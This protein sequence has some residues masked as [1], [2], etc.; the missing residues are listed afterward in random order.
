MASDTSNFLIAE[1]QLILDEARRQKSERIK[2]LGSPIQLS[3]KAL[4]IQVR[5]N[6]AWVA[7]NTAVARKL[8]LESGKTVQLYKGHTGPVTTL[9]FC[10]KVF[11]SGDEKILITGAWDQTIKLWDAD[12]K[13]LLSSTSEAHGDFVKSLFVLPSLNLLV[14]SGS[15]KIVRFWDLSTPQQKESLRSMGS[16]SSHTRPVECLDGKLL[17]DTSAMLYTADTMGV[18]KSWVLTKE[19]GPWP[20]WRGTLQEELTHHRTR[21]NE[22]LYGN[23]HLW[24]A[25]SDET[26]QSL[27]RDTDTPPPKRPALSISHPVGVR[28]VLPLALTE[29]AEPYLITGAGDILRVYDISTPEEPE[30][31]RDLDAHWHD[32]TAIRLWKR[33]TVGGDGKTRIEPWI[34]STSLDGTI[35][36]WRLSEL[37]MPAPSSG[38]EPS[39]IA[40]APANKVDGFQMT[41]DEERE[42]AELSGSD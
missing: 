6:Y 40:P 8:D 18:I 38:P 23:G 25:S 21:I 24:T 16:I 39:T 28:S 2:T 41:E 11:G 30:L 34:I 22:M 17:S 4:S 32:I 27:H 15:D 9:A 12:S 37:L 20:R 1:A 10:D 35:R 7:E 14:S 19:D 26:V 5:G 3:G 29:L 31:L 33:V 36:K 42:L 13:K